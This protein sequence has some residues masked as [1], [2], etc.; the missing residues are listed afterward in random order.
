V[1]ARKATQGKWNDSV[2][3]FEV[4]RE[5]S[6]CNSDFN[7]MSYWHGDYE[8]TVAWHEPL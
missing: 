7:A 6:I 4:R 8:Q 2:L 3:Q 1:G 5:K